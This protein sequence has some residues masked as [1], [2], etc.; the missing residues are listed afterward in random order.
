MRVFSNAT[1][2]RRSFAHL[3]RSNCQSKTKATLLGFTLVELLVVIAIIGVL[4]ALLLPAVQAARESARRSQCANNLKQLALAL[5]SYESAKQVFPTGGE[6]TQKVDRSPPGGGPPGGP[7]PG[8][9]PPG[10][11]PPGGSGPKPPS[12]GDVNWSNWSIES[13]PFVEQTALYDQYDKTREND[14]PVNEPVLQTELD[15]MQCPSDI[16]ARGFGPV[17]RYA[18]GSYQGVAGVMFPRNGQSGPGPWVS[19]SI[20]SGP[21]GNDTRAHSE[22]LQ[23]RGILHVT[24]ANGLRAE[25]TK[26]VT[27]GLSNTLMIGEFHP[28]GDPPRHVFWASTY[29]FFNKRSISANPLFRQTDHQQC[30]INQPFGKKERWLCENLLAST[31]AGRGGN[32]AKADGS[33]TYLS[34]DTEGAIYEAMATIAGNDE[35]LSDVRCFRGTGS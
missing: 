32:W 29:R 31:H 28:T 27:D 35:Y 14:D 23:C 3:S 34:A 5:L 15:V 1:L 19:W 16:E 22:N 25:R 4:F 26:D 17:R 24:G 20:Y 8:G 11:P 9:P 7:P 21:A 6:T 12:F 33:V 18:R 2:C 13:L 30:T 10:G